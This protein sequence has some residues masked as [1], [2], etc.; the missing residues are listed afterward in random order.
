MTRKTT[1][2][3]MTFLAG[4]MAIV[5]ISA[6][7]NINDDLVAHFG[8]DGNVNDYSGGSNDGTVSGTERYSTGPMDTSFKFDGSTYIS[9]ANESN[10]DF[11]ETTEFTLA[12][13]IKRSANGSTNTWF[14]KGS[15]HAD[16]T[17]GGL[18]FETNV[19]NT[20]C[21]LDEPGESS[22]AKSAKSTNYTSYDLTDWHHIA[23]TNDGSNLTIYVDGKNMTTSRTDT[24][25]GSSLN[26]FNLRLGDRGDGAT[27]VCTAITSPDCGMD[28]VRIYDVSLTTTQIQEIY[29]LSPFVQIEIIQAEQ[30]SLQNQVTSV[31][32]TVQH[33]IEEIDDLYDFWDD[34]RASIITWLAAR[35]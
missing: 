20:E 26:N 35:P 15:N 14:G 4:M 24:L 2:L 18:Y 13:W 29:E 9:L 27:K 11:D 16:S 6:S 28:D 22:G 5:P 1:I 31:N 12:S 19:N 21:W 32:A 34:L 33:N 7:A 30:T 23:C 10:F 17:Y 3:T 25:T 8:F